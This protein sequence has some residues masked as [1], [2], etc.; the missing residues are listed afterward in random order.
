MEKQFLYDAVEENAS[1]VITLS[2]KI[3]DFAEL[4]ME[5]YQ[6]AEYYC[7][8]LEREGFTVQRQLCGI[9]TA[10][11]GSFGSG[12]P[13]IGILGEFDALSGLSQVPGS[14]QRQCLT[15]GGNGQG[16]NHNL[17]GAASFGAALAVKKAMEAGLLHGTVI[18]YGCPG[19]EG[20][21]GK[22]FMA[23]DGMFRDLDA[24]LT[25]HPGDTNEIKVGASAACIQVE[26]SFHGIA[27]H[28]AGDPY[29]GRSALDAVEL[30]HVGVQFLREHMPPNSSIHY[31]IPDG[32]GVS[33]NVVQSGAKTI[34]MVR[35][36][37]VRKAKALL[38]RV[39]NIAKGAALMTDTSFTFR[40]IDGTASTVGNQVLEQVMYENL[41]QAPIPVYTREERQ[42]AHDLHR[43]F[44]AELP[45]ELTKT[46]PTVR[47]FVRRETEDGKRDIN[48][49]IMPYVP[50]WAYSPGST[51]VGDVSWLTP[52]AQFTTACRVSGS[53]GHSWQNVSIGRTSFAHK[54]MLQ[55]AKV[56]AGTAADLMT[57][58]A[59]LEKAREE[60]RQAAAEG[61][62]CPIGPELKPGPQQ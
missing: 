49:F 3:W 2:D 20:C 57:D 25:W 56:L 17:L 10:F 5:E 44:P 52:T 7:D 41:K 14:A 54:G 22:T 24:A 21:A 28:A 31:S 30:M 36:E 35:G 11:S 60:F 19:E 4:S 50:S 39:D 59:L 18:F 62:D 1:T 37:T 9:P 12:S 47:A 6:S 8:L 32:G 27:A 16:C 40:Q 38:Q 45:G 34:F 29:N 43:T 33:P 46:D 55:A 58:P 15:E 23:R 53:P 26:Y 48:D 13:R 42:F 61:Y 51:D